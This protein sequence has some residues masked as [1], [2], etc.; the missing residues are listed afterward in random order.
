MKEPILRIRA[1]K[2]SNPKRQLENPLVCFFSFLKEILKTTK[3]EFNV[4][5]FV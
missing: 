5:R 1:K 4:E 2:F 3:I